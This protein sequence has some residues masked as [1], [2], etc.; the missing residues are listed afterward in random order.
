MR[1][2]ELAALSGMKV[3]TIRYY[4]TTGLIAAP[5]RSRSGYRMYRPEHLQRLTFLRRC[6]ELG[7]SIKEIRELLSLTENP[8]QSCASVTTIA[9]R[10][11]ED[12][13]SKLD[14]LQRL[15]QALDGLVASC[16]T[17]RVGD[18]KILHALATM[19]A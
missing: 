16:G 8:R 12:V 18:C 3:V 2:G 13:R 6:R 5:S 14:D 10:H 4:E 17:G 11:L 1:I 7:F 15:Q 9:A 19:P